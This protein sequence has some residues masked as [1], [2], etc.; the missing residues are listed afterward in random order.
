M[1]ANGKRMRVSLSI[2]ES[3]VMELDKLVIKRGFES[4]SMAVAEMLESQMVLH[5]EKLGNEVMAGTVTLI[6]DRG[7]PSC[8][9]KI[10]ELQYKYVIEVISSLHINLEQHQVMEVILVQGPAARLKRLA[11]AMIAVKGV[12][13]GQLNLNTSIL[14]QLHK[15]TEPERTEP[16]RTEP[17]KSE[18]HS[19]EHEENYE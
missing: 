3:L 13:T 14:P 9:Q 10:A 1:S 7:R 4:R 17:E 5:K 15:R 8:Q 12:K 19:D 11:D 16:E 6:Y 18:S 2:P